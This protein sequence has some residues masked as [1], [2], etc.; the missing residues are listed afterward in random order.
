MS[1][2]ADI[3]KH[4]PAFYKLREKKAEGKNPAASA[5]MLLTQDV[6]NSCLRVMCEWARDSHSRYLPR[7]N[8]R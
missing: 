5:L 3:V 2:H 8:G 7:K 4:F 1:I 6:E